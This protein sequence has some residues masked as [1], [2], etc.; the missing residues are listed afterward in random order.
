MYGSA[1]K[2]LG[3]I[4]GM[5]P[6]AS[7]YFIRRIL[8]LTPAPKEWDH[9]RM[10]VDYNITIPSRTRCLLYGEAS[11]LPGI[12]ETVNGLGRAGA[13]AVVIPCNSAHHWYEAASK[14]LEV[15]WL[16]LIEITANAVKKQGL[17]NVLVAGAYV[18]VT[19]R[20]YDP[21]LENTFYLNEA[22]MD[23]LYRIIERLKLDEDKA[24]IKRDFYELVAPY[25]G[26]VEGIVLACTEPS[27]L[28]AKGE[29]TLGDFGV[30]DSAH[31]YAKYC[32]EQCKGITL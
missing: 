18:T 27:M 6:F 7:T 4:A 25:Q 30:V 10:H 21:Y 5:G 19:Q 8:E 1:M 17:R 28:F 14:E 2:T 3:V 26:K 22:E 16:N 13:D 24:E 9:I 15:P 11:P 29:N 12:I 32:V 31:E 20:L 23:T